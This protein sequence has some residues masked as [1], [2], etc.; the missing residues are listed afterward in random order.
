MTSTTPT[1]TGA[2][3][4]P[5]GSTTATTA[6][7]TR[8]NRM[9]T[10]DFINVGIFTALYYVVFFATGMI[11]FINPILMF[12]GWAA[13]LILNGIVIALFIARTP[14]FGA[15][16][17]LSVILSIL[18]VATGHPIYLIP[19]LLVIGVVCD[20]LLGRLRGRPSLGVPLVYAIFS[21]WLIVPLFPIL[22][23]ADEYYEQLSAQMGADYVASMRELFQPWIIG[24]WAIVV[25]I[26]AWLGGILGVR[27]G[28]R[29]FSRAGLA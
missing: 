12:V 19:A 21:L 6:T 11:G 28:R 13:G 26:L 5:T 22:F 27:V 20:L 29:H 18:W 8:G 9:T 3:T 16:T 7:E 2:T 25:F 14:R 4:G 24:A 23:A 15:M 10:R 17:L 1:G